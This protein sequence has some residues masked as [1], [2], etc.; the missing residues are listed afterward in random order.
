MTRLIGNTQHVITALF[1]LLALSACDGG[2]P[3]QAPNAQN[4]NQAASPATAAQP[5]ISNPLTSEFIPATDAVL[6]NPPPGDW[7]RWRRDHGATGY[8]PLDEVTPQNVNNLQLAW[9][10][11]MEAGGME[12]EPIVYHGIMYLPHTNGVVQ[13]LDARSGDLLWEYRRAFEGNTDGDTTRNIAIYNDKI[14]LTT[15]DAY[16]VALDAR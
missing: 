4:N 12:Q 5:E 9:A 7:L 1:V 3:S 8:S 6:Q 14:Y 15:P 2:S 11:T 16:L 10:W 13:A